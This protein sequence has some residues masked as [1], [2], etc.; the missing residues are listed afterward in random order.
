MSEKRLRQ[1]RRA[2]CGSI[3]INETYFKIR[4]KWRCLY[5]AID[6]HGD[7]VDFLLTAKLARDKRTSASGEAPANGGRSKRSIARRQILLK[8]SP[9]PR[10]PQI[11]WG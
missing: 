11:R 3:P 9:R 4:G 5:G 10:S 7:P 6:K 8:R 1:F 2:H